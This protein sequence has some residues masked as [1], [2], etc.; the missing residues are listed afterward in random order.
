MMQD[1]ADELERQ[2]EALMTLQQKRTISDFSRFDELFSSAPDRG[3]KF[4]TPLKYPFKSPITA[5]KRDAG[6]PIGKIGA[7]SVPK[8][9]SEEMIELFKKLIGQPRSLNE[10]D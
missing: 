6:K 3:I 10:I 9:P 2:L 1:D 7:I 5:F 4:G 8:A